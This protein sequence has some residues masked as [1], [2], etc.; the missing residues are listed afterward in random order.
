MQNQ[1]DKSFSIRDEL[2]EFL[3]VRNISKY[4]SHAK[5]VKIHSMESKID[6]FVCSHTKNCFK[7]KQKIVLGNKCLQLLI[8]S[9]LNAKKLR[10]CAGV[11]FTF[12]TVY[13]SSRR[14][15]RRLN[16]QKL[17]LACETLWLKCLTQFRFS[18]WRSFK[19]SEG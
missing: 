4:Q 13:S 11:S 16:A 17:V 14:S 2:S 3:S 7:N 1:Q 12:Y 9:R 18:V 6:D 5:K 15:S 19:F 10:V 8:K